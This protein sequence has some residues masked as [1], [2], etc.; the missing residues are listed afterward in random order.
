MGSHAQEISQVREWLLVLGYSMFKTGLVSLKCPQ[1]F[2][3]ELILKFALMIRQL[4]AQRTTQR[5]GAMS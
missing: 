5:R 4:R 1:I 2:W 3:D